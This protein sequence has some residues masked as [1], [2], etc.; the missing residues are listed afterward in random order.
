M[1][2]ILIIFSL[3]SFQSMARPAKHPTPNDALF[4][5]VKR[6]R[7]QR[8]KRTIRFVA[9]RVALLFCMHGSDFMPG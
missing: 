2:H 9:R 1:T 3:F 8:P 6:P 4:D 7:C 5:G